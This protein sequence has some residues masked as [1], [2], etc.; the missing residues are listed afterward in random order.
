MWRMP[1]FPRTTWQLE[2]CH[3]FDSMAPRQRDFSSL[4]RVLL[5]VGESGGT[6]GRS[7]RRPNYAAAAGP[8]GLRTMTTTA[9]RLSFQAKEIV[10]SAIESSE[11]SLSSS[12]SGFPATAEDT[13]TPLRGRLLKR[14]QRSMTAAWG[15]RYFEVD[16]VLGLLLYYNTFDDLDRRTPSRLYPLSDLSHIQLHSSCFPGSSSREH[17]FEVSFA[18]PHAPS[19]A[20]R[21]S[22]THKLILAACSRDE[23]LCW[24]RGLSRRLARHNDAQQNSHEFRRFAVH[25]PEDCD[26]HMGIVVR[27]LEGQPIGVEV[28]QLVRGD[29]CSRA[30]LV[31]GDILL[32][33]EGQACLSHTHAIKLLTRM[34]RMAKGRKALE[35]LVCRSR[36][37]Q[38]VEKEGDI[39]GGSGEVARAVPHGH[40]SQDDTSGSTLP[41]P[42]RP[43]SDALPSCRPQQGAPH[44]TRA[45]PPD[46]VVGPID[47][48]EQSAT[49][50]SESEPGEDAELLHEKLPMQG[51]LPPGGSVRRERVLAYAWLDSTSSSAV[52]TEV[53][54]DDGTS[55]GKFG[56]RTL[57]RCEDTG[58]TKPNAGSVG[59]DGRWAPLTDFAIEEA[60]A[61]C[62][63]SK[64]AP[65][66]GFPP[67]A[68]SQRS[69][70]PSTDTRAVSLSASTATAGSIERALPPAPPPGPRDLQCAS[71][72]S[73]ARRWQK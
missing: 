20:A 32:A 29:L 69:P 36:D 1:N 27:N 59:P 46:S 49:L 34:G 10:H 31:Q 54:T 64:V 19:Q 9:R 30:G 68:W 55:N 39:C 72:R 26:A 71:P 33:V 62:Q 67:D 23:Q 2:K 11:D 41:M 47:V 25:L 73:S 28:I 37:R 8:A 42:L 24:A 66:D 6:A 22:C 45:P 56:D 48:S 53:R 4:R 14:H 58:D 16:D 21:G 70:H 3:M 57:R 52:Q 63:R 5:R 60:I 15:V 43:R 61:R 7:G 50:A 12:E 13:T 65:V 40:C 51:T 18:A 17:A 38:P 35:L 44:A